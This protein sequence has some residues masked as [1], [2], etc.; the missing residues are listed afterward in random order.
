MGLGVSP[1][2]IFLFLRSPRLT[3]VSSPDVSH[4]FPEFPVP[5]LGS[6]LLQESITLRDV[7]ALQLAYRRHCQVTAPA[8]GGLGGRGDGAPCPLQGPLWAAA[9]LFPGPPV[10]PVTPTPAASRVMAPG[11]GTTPVASMDPVASPQATLDVVTN[12][13]FHYIEQLWLSFW[14]SKATSGDGP[15]SLPAR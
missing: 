8:L 10:S 7:K 15:D 6:G 2:P 14:N 1:H 11:Q 5:E 9:A 12:L 3:A 4:V 13:Q